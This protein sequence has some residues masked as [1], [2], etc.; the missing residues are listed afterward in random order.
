MTCLRIWKRA[1]GF[2]MLA[3]TLSG[4]SGCLSFLNPVQQP[5][6]EILQSCLDLPKCSRDHVHVFLVNGL[7]PFNYGNLTGVRDYLH[8]LGFHQTYY[9]QFFHT[10]WYKNE[11]HRIQKEDPEA[12]FVLIGFSL[13][14]NV[15]DWLAKCLK[16][17][18][19]FI[20]LMV[21]LSGNHPVQPM[22]HERPENVG[23]VVNIL[24]SGIMQARGERDWAENHQPP[25]T[26]HFALP[27]NQETLEILAEALRQV[28]AA[29]PVTEKKTSP[30]PS[31][32]DSGPSPRPVMP[33][34]SS[35][36]DEWDFLK[37]VSRRKN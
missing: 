26:G 7:D 23:R 36:Q 10:G 29:V 9:G 15:V 28:A 24:A 2:W 34:V 11:I 12:H 18:G 37:P 4:G 19:I 27:T 1:L 16:E 35:K 22:P 6:P 14:M 3:V 32:E 33:K 8:N 30:V 13:G 25:K 17:D 5:P 31:L 20:D 21:W